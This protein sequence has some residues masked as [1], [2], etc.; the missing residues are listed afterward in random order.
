MGSASCRYDTPF[1]ISLPQMHSILVFVPFLTQFVLFCLDAPQGG[2]LSKETKIESIRVL[3]PCGQVCLEESRCCISSNSAQVCCRVL[4]AE[5]LSTDAEAEDSENPWWQLVGVL[6]P[7]FLHGLCMCV[8][9]SRVA[10]GLLPPLVSGVTRLVRIPYVFTSHRVFLDCAFD[11]FCFYFS[12]Y[13]AAPGAP[14]GGTISSYQQET[15]R[16]SSCVKCR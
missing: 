15:Q 12:G 16:G 11:F 1:A 5:S 10:E 14:F 3:S 2:L 13:T 6:L 4:S 8:D 7:P 9:R